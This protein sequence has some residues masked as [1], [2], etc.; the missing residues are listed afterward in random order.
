MLN[1]KRHAAPRLYLRPRSNQAG[2]APCDFSRGGVVHS[3]AAGRP[4]VV[5]GPRSD[6]GRQ[7]VADGQSAA[8]PE[9]PR[10]DDGG[11][12]GRRTGATAEQ[13]LPEATETSGDCEVSFACA[14][15]DP[16]PVGHAAAL[17]HA[18][19]LTAPLTWRRRRAAFIPA[20]RGHLHARLRHRHI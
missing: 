17:R 10:P 15:Q 20:A 3:P 8:A 14:R 12:A 2:V 13:W 5:R 1:R 9:R 11:A 19:T 6:G 18:D 4:G 7:A 16:L